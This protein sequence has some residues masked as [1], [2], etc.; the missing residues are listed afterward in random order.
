LKI[1]VMGGTFDPIHTGHLIIAQEA[2]WL[3]GLDKILFIPAKDPPHKQK[4]EVTPAFHRAR[5]V[6]LAI[7]GKPKFELST[8]EMERTGLS[9]TA[10]TLEA[11]SEKYGNEAELHFIIGVDA[12]ADIGKWYKPERVVALAKL[13]VARRPGYQLSLEKLTRDLPQVENRIEWVDTPIIEIAAQEIR[14]RVL[15]NA[16]ISYLVPPLVEEYIYRE[17]LYL[18][19]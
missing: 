16:P 2:G 13:A 1:G 6:Q 11:L 19:G 3:L 14:E 8:I 7:E 10:D 15:N 17:R 12:A 18:P 5:M 9:Y 4:Q